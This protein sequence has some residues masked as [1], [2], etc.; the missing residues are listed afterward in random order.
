M[1]YKRRKK[2]SKGDSVWE[3]NRTRG[4]CA[5]SGRPI[6]GKDRHP[7]GDQCLYLKCD[8]DKANPDVQIVGRVKAGTDEV[9]NVTPDGRAFRSVPTGRHR[10]ARNSCQEEYNYW[11]RFCNVAHPDDSEKTCRAP[12][13]AIFKWQEGRP[14][15]GLDA[16]G[17]PVVKWHDVTVWEH[18]VIADE[19]IARGFHVPTLADGKFR[20]TE[21][22]PGERTVG[23]SNSV[24]EVPEAPIMD[25]ARAGMSPQDWG[26]KAPEEPEPTPV[27]VVE[28]ELV[29]ERVQPQENALSAE[30]RE[31]LA[32]L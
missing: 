23:H 5:L 12:T 6:Q 30:D 1:A 22:K 32:S 31:W 17:E 16:N 18:A 11:Q 21:A 24:S 14:T 3:A 2:K 29:G 9:E 20:T 27:A 4:N 7:Q 13:K 10:C 28:P 8:G 26:E 15:G 25:L 19:A